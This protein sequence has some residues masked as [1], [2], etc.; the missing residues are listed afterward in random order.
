MRRPHR[1]LRFPNRAALIPASV[2]NLA[3]HPTPGGHARSF[4]LRRHNLRGA[5]NALHH[6]A[7][8]L[9][10][11]AVT[12]AGPSSAPPPPMTP[13]S[14]ASETP[15]AQV[16]PAAPQ[17]TWRERIGF[18]CG[19]LPFN[20]GASG[21]NTIAYPIY[22]IT[23]GLSPTLVGIVLAIARLWDGFM[24]PVVGHVSDNSRSKWGRRRP[25]IAVGAVLCALTFPIIWLVPPEWSKPAMFG[26][27]LVTTLVFYTAFAVYAVP[28]LTLGFELSTDSNERV[29]IHAVRAVVSK[30]TFF[31]IP[32]VFAVAQ[33]PVFK[34]TVDG[35]RTLGWIIG[36]LFLVL[37]LPAMLL[38]R[39][40]YAARMVAQ[41]KVPARENLR[42]TFQ[43]RPFL[44]LVGIVLGLLIGTT[45]VGNL[46][47]YVNSYYVFGGDTV[48]G[49]AMHARAQTLYAVTGMIAVPIV[50][51][52]ATRYGKLRVI[53]WCIG[54]GV[55]ASISEFFFFN[56]EYPWLQYLSMLLL[57]PSFSGFWVLVD[58]MKADVAD[59]DEH[60]TGLRRE[61][62]YASVACW[63][64]K[65]A[66]TLAMLAS[67]F[68]LDLSGFDV[69]RGGAQ[70]ESALLTIRL[71]FAGVPALFLLG[72]LILAA[73][74]PLN[75]AEVR[76]IKSSLDT[77]VTAR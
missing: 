59:Y 44:Y 73:R 29:R 60:R 15:P 40:R 19:Q 36:G 33:L 23:L 49:A 2:S 20:F 6:L 56:R 74:Y 38:T 50:S 58:P 37:G 31:I 55:L 12:I 70:D 1:H 75:D 52:L 10:A 71:A 76:R 3:V 67:G 48:A 72:S 21:L 61:G 53:R 11:P 5:R 43:N 69:A 22:N 35:M 45:L 8:P 4:L 17:T 13:V 26:Y 30:L 64:E 47:I 65:T 34:S 25:F 32:W 41:K 9:H 42:L 54:C 66:L 24:D 27:F 28:Y 62:M 18:A 14:P 77:P 63:L 68:V 39:E 16:A 57:A 7:L 51:S 46:G